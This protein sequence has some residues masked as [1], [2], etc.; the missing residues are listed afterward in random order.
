MAPPT[1][2]NCTY[3]FPADW[4]NLSWD[5]LVEK[6][7]EQKPDLWKAAVPESS[8]T[9]L[10]SDL[11]NALSDK[12]REAARKRFDLLTKL[13]KR[14]GQDNSTSL[15]TLKAYVQHKLKTDDY[16]FE[17]DAKKL[18][19]KGEALLI[20]T[21]AMH[22][23]ASNYCSEAGKAAK[24]TAPATKPPQ[25]AEP[26][27]PPRPPDPPPPPRPKRSFWSQYGGTIVRVAQWGAVALAAI[28]AVV[29]AIIFVRRVGVFGKLR[30][31]LRRLPDL[32]S[33]R[34][35]APVRN[36]YR[37]LPD[38]TPRIPPGHTVRGVQLP[39]MN[40]AMAFD[41][42]TFRLKRSILLR[43]VEAYVKFGK[44]D[45]ATRAYKDLVELTE[46]WHGVWGFSDLPPLFP[47]EVTRLTAD[48]LN[49]IRRLL[50][51]PAD[52]MPTSG[53]ILTINSNSGQGILSWQEVRR[54]GKILQN[55][56]H[57]SRT[58]KDNGERILRALY[59]IT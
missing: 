1:A 57:T 16:F 21:A 9:I 7:K 37:G 58:K 54:L 45:D 17:D 19:R 6:A 53:T 18:E 52:R 44:M 24:P 30:T 3:L 29:V 32:W 34:P 47:R 11:L 59:R 33:S 43:E 5:Q 39:S 38:L 41:G 28:A 27:A 15:A 23:F 25:P 26:P 49:I 46:R 56:A 40:E 8:Q 55:G 13:D 4:S 10:H 2:K 48:D 22:L 14:D 50:Q 20:E 31:L 12:Q 35:F 36:R 42:D 51:L